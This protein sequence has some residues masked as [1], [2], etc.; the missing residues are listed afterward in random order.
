[1]AF[2]TIFALC[3][4]K[5]FLRSWKGGGLVVKSIFFSGQRP[6]F[7]SQHTQGALQLLLIPVRVNLNS[8]SSAQYTHTYMQIKQLHS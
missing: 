2:N 3:L 4:Q 8:S 7:S 1:M 5:Y 6:G